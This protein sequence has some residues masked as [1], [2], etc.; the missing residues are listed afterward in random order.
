MIIFQSVR[1]LSPILI[2]TLL[3]LL[4]YRWTLAGSQTDMKSGSGNQVNP[5]WCLLSPGWQHPDLTKNMVD[6]TLCPPRAWSLTWPR[7]SNCELEGCRISDKLESDRCYF[8][9]T[10]TW[11]I[12][13]WV[14]P[15]LLVA[16]WVSEE[17]YFRMYYQTGSKWHVF[18]DV[19]SNRVSEEIYSHPFGDPLAVLWHLLQNKQWTKWSYLINQEIVL[20]AL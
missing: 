13:T 7:T 10:S 14:C 8:S 15:E 16:D 2:I 17:I 9:T 11:K 19:L 6:N 1:P 5:G 18:S 12:V 20:L 4:S 3:L